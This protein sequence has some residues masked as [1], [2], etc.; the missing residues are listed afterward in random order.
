MKFLD[1]KDFRKVHQ[2]DHTA[3]LS[4][5]KG[6]SITVLIKKLSP[7]QQEQLKSLKLYGGGE[8][9]GVH[10]PADDK[11]GK[12]ESIAGSAARESKKDRPEHQE[13]HRKTAIEEHKQVLA[14][15]Q[16]MPAPKLQNLDQGGSVQ[17]DSSGYP[18]KSGS[19]PLPP[20]APPDQA[21]A[22]GFASVFHADGGPI[23]A[24]HMY[25]DQK[26]PVAADDAAPQTD[27]PVANMAATP[28]DTSMAAQP[29]GNVPL[30]NPNGTVNAPAALNLGQTAAREQQGV[31]ATKGANTAVAEDAYMKQRAELA[32]RDQNLYKELKGHADD[33]AHYIQAHPINPNAYKENMDTGDKLGVALGMFAGGLKQG[34]LVAIILPWTFLINK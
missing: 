4:S 13:Q 26:A 30:E 14:E 27:N 3:T 23:E 21:K 31:E 6:H 9:K 12:G 16:A 25:A 11:S 18:I 17:Y 28:V 32:Q 15:S 5:P 33:F 10:R 7:L 34:L 8:V 29:Q 24:R 20:P 2:D 1:I 22:S 19:A